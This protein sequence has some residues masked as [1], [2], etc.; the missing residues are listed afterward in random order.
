MDP[1]VT[2]VRSRESNR[3][4]NGPLDPKNNKHA[5]GERVM[6]T[7]MNDESYKQSIHQC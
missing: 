7:A 1:D 6:N 5:F 3:G 2:Q 4:E